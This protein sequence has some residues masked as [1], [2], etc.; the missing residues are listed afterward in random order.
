M[1]NVVKDKYQS[2]LIFRGQCLYWDMQKLFVFW[3]HI[4]LNNINCD[5]NLYAYTEAKCSI[6]WKW[7][8]WSSIIIIIIMLFFN[9]SIAA[10]KNYV[11]QLSMN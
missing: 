9:Y 5:I 3:R 7:K 11:R 6:F 4:R 8:S 2:H 1:R 10:K